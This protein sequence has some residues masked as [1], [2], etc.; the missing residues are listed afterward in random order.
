MVHAS[1]LCSDLD[2]KLGGQ[3]LHLKGGDV[4]AIEY[5]TSVAECDESAAAKTGLKPRGINDVALMPLDAP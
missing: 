4:G 2:V 3:P 1:F 5:M